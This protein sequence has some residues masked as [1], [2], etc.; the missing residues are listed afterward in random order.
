MQ[1]LAM[2]MA[3]STSASTAEGAEDGMAM[4]E[5]GFVTVLEALK[6]TSGMVGRGHLSSA[7]W[8]L[9][10]RPMQRMV[11]ISEMDRGDSSC[12][13][14][15]WIHYVGRCLWFECFLSHSPS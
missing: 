2:T 5:E 3:S 6:K 8:S 12:E 15:S 4:G 9:K 1:S 10:L 14:Q 7:A 13:S 11:P